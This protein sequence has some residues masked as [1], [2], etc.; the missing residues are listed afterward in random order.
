MFA[1]WFMLFGY[2]DALLAS[3]SCHQISLL[4]RKFYVLRMVNDIFDRVF[5]QHLLRCWKSVCVVIPMRKFPKIPEK[6]ITYQTKQAKSLLG[7]RI[8]NCV[9]FSL[10]MLKGK[11][12]QLLILLQASYSLF[13]GVLLENCISL[14]REAEEE[15]DDDNLSERQAGNKKFP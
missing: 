6:K 2:T 5:T 9:L 10:L 15:C 8:E 12:L 4:Q 7:N 1:R 13:L 3:K 14:L 11:S